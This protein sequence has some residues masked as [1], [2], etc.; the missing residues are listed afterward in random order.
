MANISTVTNL[1]INRLSQAKYEQLCAAG[2]LDPYQLYMTDSSQL[3]AKNSQINNVASPVVGTDAAN[4]DYV[5][6]CISNIEIPTDLSCFSNSPNYVKQNEIDLGYSNQTLWLSSKSYITSVDCADFIKDGMLSTAALC[7]TTLILTFNTDASCSPISVE[8]SNFVDNYDSKISYLSCAIDKKIFI[9]DRISSISG[10]SDLSIVK[11][12][13]SEYAQVLQNGALSNA[14]YIVQD[15]FMDA[16]GQQLRNLSAGTLSSDAVTL[17]QLE[18]V[19]ASLSGYYQK[20]ETSSANQISIAFD[21]LSD[22]YQAKGDYLSSIPND[23][24]TYDET[25]SAL[26]SDGYLMSSDIVSAIGDIQTS[27]FQS[28]Q[29]PSA[30]VRS[31]QETLISVLNILRKNQGNN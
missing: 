27:L 30:S 11:L 21:G 2:Q 3:D 5:D 26:S 16:Y 31:I 17:A 1:I 15:T 4:K 14:L 28:I 22:S 10:N 19:S 24:K 20:S 23:Y 7:G 6:N 29:N 18:D 8:L 13:S 9:D 25:L 12:N